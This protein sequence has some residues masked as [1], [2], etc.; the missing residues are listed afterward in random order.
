[1]KLRAGRRADACVKQAEKIVFFLS[2][3][4]S[5][6]FKKWRISKVESYKGP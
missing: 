6:A 3:G 2:G 4:K 1:M 5:I